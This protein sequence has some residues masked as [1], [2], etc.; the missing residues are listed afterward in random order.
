MG[1]SWLT[2]RNGTDGNLHQFSSSFLLICCQSR[3]AKVNFFILRG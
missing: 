2:E 1:D 3:L